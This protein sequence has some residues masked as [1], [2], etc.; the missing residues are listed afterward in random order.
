MI[1]A[2]G[3]CQ[4][5]ATPCFLLFVLVR[6]LF[7]PVYQLNLNA[8]RSVVFFAVRRHHELKE[9]RFRFFVICPNITPAVAYGSGLACSRHCQFRC[10]QHSCAPPNHYCRYSIYYNSSRV[11]LCGMIVTIFVKFAAISNADP[12]QSAHIGFR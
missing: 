5:T 3:H 9:I 6:T 7:Q 4:S 1:I 10:F 12:V 8:L 11:Q 2:T